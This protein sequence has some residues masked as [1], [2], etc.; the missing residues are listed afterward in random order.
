MLEDNVMAEIIVKDWMIEDMKLSGLSLLAFALIYTC[1]QKGKGGWFGGYKDLAQRIGS[2]ERGAIK[3]INTLLTD[4]LIVKD[5]IVINGTV[6]TLLMTKERYELC[7]HEQNSDE[8]SSE[9]AMNSVQCD[10]NSSN[11]NI[12]TIQDTQG[13]TQIKKNNKEKSLVFPFSS[14]R[15]MSVWRTL[16]SQ[17]KWKK[18]TTDALQYSLNRLSKYSESFVIMLMEEAIEHNWQG[19]VFDNTDTRY[20]AW[21]NSNP[22]AKEEKYPDG[23]Y[24]KK[25]FTYDEL[26]ALFMDNDFALFQH[27]LRGGSVTRKDGKWK[28]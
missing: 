8:Q 6:R 18:K 26:K 1:T 19:V 12:H 2:T 27:I 23:T 13:K 20:N 25:D 11:N 14:D 21:C 15:F 9:H 5:D 16:V 3:A 22:Q 4:S 10:L 28:R 17:P 7:S 24:W